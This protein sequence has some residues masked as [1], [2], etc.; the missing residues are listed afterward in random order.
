MKTGFIEEFGA[1]FAEGG[2]G[3]S[4]IPPSLSFP[5]VLP[6]KALKRNPGDKDTAQR[7]NV[8]LFLLD[9]SRRPLRHFN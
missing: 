9:R 8:R 3:K 7:I 1:S 5:S 2:K 4:A 6:C